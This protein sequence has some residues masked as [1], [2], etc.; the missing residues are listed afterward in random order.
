MS[1]HTIYL[2]HHTH[3]DIGYTHDQPVVWELH[4]RFIDRAI[5]LA[6]RDQAVDA[7]HAF[8][9]T[10]EALG[11]VLHW[12]QLADDPRRARFL[13]LAQAG[14]I[15]VTAMFTH[16][17]P[18]ADTLANIDLL[19]HV[20]RAR[21]LGI[22][23]RH[24]LSCDINGH[25]WPLVDALLDAGIETL[26]MAVNEFN[27]GAPFTRPNLF[28]WLAPSRRPLTVLN[29]WIY[30][31]GNFAGII[32]LL[33]QV[34]DQALPPPDLAQRLERLDKS[35]PAL[36]DILANAGWPLPVALL[37]CTHAFGDNGA[38]DATI[39][40]FVREW[41]ARPKRPRHPRPR[42]VLA[43]LTMWWDAVRQCGVEF[44][45]AAGDWT[46]YWAFGVGSAAREA[47]VARAAQV[48]LQ[49]ADALR[50]LTNQAPAAHSAPA[51]AALHL[52]NEHTFESDA[53]TDH[54][55]GTD[56][57]AV[58]HHKAH[59]AWQL[60]SLAKFQLRDAVADLARRVTRGADDTLLLYN[61]LPWP[62]TVS[63]PVR[64]TVR[65]PRGADDDAG[66]ARHYQDHDAPVHARLAPVTVPA[67]GYT[68]VSAARVIPIPAAIRATPAEQPHLTNRWHRLV[69]D[70]WHGGLISW[71]NA[72][73]TRQWLD[74]QAPWR[75]AT[76]IREDPIPHAYDNPR[77]VFSSNDDSVW[78]ITGHGRNWHPRW[79]AER[80]ATA[81]A[82]R[83][84]YE[85]LPDG[86]RIT[87][88]LG[89]DLPKLPDVT[90][91]TF[92]PDHAPWVEFEVELDLGLTVTP[93]AY[94]FPLPFAM[95]QPAIHL[96]V[97]GQ[98][99]QV[100]R[101]QLP[102]VNRDY[103]T[104]QR[105]CALAERQRHIHIATP[106]NPLVMFGG[107]HFGA[108]R[109]EAVTD[110]G[111]FLGWLANNYWLVNFRARQPGKVRA[112]YRVTPQDTAFDEPAAHRLGLEAA[113]P[114]VMHNLMEPPLTVAAP[115]P[116][117]G[118][119]LHLPPPPV[120][121]TQISGD[122]TTVI[123]RLTNAGDTPRPATVGSALQTITAA[124]ESDFFTR[125]RRPLP[126]RRGKV[127]LPLA[128]RQTV[129]LRLKTQPH[130]RAS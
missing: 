21:D 26:T 17:L 66:A 79:R 89:F 111:L 107:F 104:I 36:K 94:Y 122:G 9:W 42:L 71:L 100:N 5:D 53:S 50:A 120:L 31:M 118:T 60:H 32:P 108:N 2:L 130:A 10:C 103:F 73:E 59:Q 39:G 101:D 18:V 30:N 33:T 84:H 11:P 76:L 87:Q 109:G 24:A 85:K 51:W 106:I 40:D 58:W 48:N 52:W 57:T 64:D 93:E 92:L 113:T 12:W 41:N 75:A 80:R 102:G 65:R 22:P 70:S 77:G 117:T 95:E 38:P 99:V 47:A 91:S 114:P 112:R 82:L 124:E 119:L 63:G 8:R 129:V 105:W 35:W 14:R 49:T 126:V 97:G 15:E 46:D 54:P 83:H 125:A 69:F 19:Q 44:P 3:T 116:S 67:L 13:R 128:P 88:R 90:V 78:T 7:P 43:T 61:P 121:A 110:S 1:I 68:T 29:N 127:T 25:N 45:A 34:G 81:T 74:L 98:A 27:G 62:R 37:P 96:D 56:S 16:Q 23:V 72:D 55:D 123:L 115:L 20:A 86:Q 6:E 28:R 4:R